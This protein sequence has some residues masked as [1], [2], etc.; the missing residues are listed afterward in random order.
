[1]YQRPTSQSTHFANELQQAFP[2]IT[3][4]LDIF[5]MPD[6]QANPPPR[7]ISSEAANLPR[8]IF[9]TSSFLQIQYFCQFQ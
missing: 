4:Q 1:M 8:I 5:Q 2:F 7:K 9:Q 6:E 3:P